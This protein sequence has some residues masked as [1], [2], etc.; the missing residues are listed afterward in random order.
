[1]SKAAAQTRY[2]SQLESKINAMLASTLGPNKAQVKVNA[3][4]NM[5]ETTQDKLEYAGAG[6]PVKTTEDSESLKGT[7][8]TARGGAAGTGSNVPTY[9]QSTNAAGGGNSSYKSKKGTTDYGVGKTV[10]KTKIATGTPNKLGVALLV[11]KSVP[12]AVFDQLKGTVATAA[13]LD[14]SRG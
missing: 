11:D 4:L 1:S 14:T 6:T 12:K 5:D 7:A 8:A 2:A 3:D 10:T 13:G 9:S